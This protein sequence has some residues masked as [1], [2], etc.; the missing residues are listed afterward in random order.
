MRLSWL[1]LN[2]LPLLLLGAL[3]LNAALADS[4]NSAHPHSDTPQQAAA[5]PPPPAPAAATRA[6]AAVT[7]AAG[8]AASAAAEQLSQASPASASTQPQ[9]DA[10]R[11]EGG[12]QTSLLQQQQLQQLQ[13][14]NQQQQQQQQEQKGFSVVWLT[15]VH[16][17]HLYTAAAP[18]HSFCHDPRRAAAA[19]AAAAG[20][21]AA[22]SQWLP[23]TAAAALQ[24]EARQQQPVFVQ[25][26]RLAEV[27]PPSGGLRLLL[28]QRRS[29]ERGGGRKE[30]AADAHKPAAAPAAAA[31]GGRG[32]MHVAAHAGETDPLLG[33]AGCDSPPALIETALHFASSLAAASQRSEGGWQGPVLP[34]TA[35]V[36]LTGDYA[37]HFSEGQT[38]DRREALRLWTSAL[39][40]HFPQSCGEGGGE[41]EAEQEAAQPAQ[42]QQQ[43]QQGRGACRRMQLLMVVGNNDL[44]A[45]YLIPAARSEWAH[46]L[47]SLWRGALPSAAETKEA[48][49]LYYS[50]ELERHP[51]VS[52]LCLNTVLYSVAARTR[53]VAAGFSLESLSQEEEADPAGQFA[54]LR[55][56]LQQART[57]KKQVIIAGHIPPGFDSHL[58]SGFSEEDLWLPRYTEKYR[59]LITEFADSVTAQLFGHLHFG[60]VRAVT[61]EAR[62]GEEREGEAGFPTALLG[63][64]ALSPIH[65]NN[66]AM[67]A[68][69]FQQQQ[70]S[71][72][73]AAAAD[74]GDSSSSKTTLADYLQYSL[75]LY[76]FVG[77]AG[78]GGV[79]PH[80]SFEYSL[81]ATFA[82]FMHAE[83]KAPRCIDGSL[84]IRMGEALRVY[85][86]AYAL[87]EWH[88]AAGGLRASSRVRSCEVLAITKEEHK[89]CLRGGEL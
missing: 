78:T 3:L 9:S 7:A 43:Q 24:Q 16:L 21:A 73:V 81:H 22:G 47:F 12:K 56:Q 32:H 20:A 71:A 74:G 58:V 17:D 77:A 48:S 5:P 4:S 19:G 30:A 33:R 59:A 1:C 75:P 49:G 85:P 23:G 62:S 54:W 72:A 11:D 87:Y 61:A 67:A 63:A 86:L 18:V 66:P 44:A 10:F 83:K 89:E 53:L 26:R 25:A 64:P 14:Q 50:T 39:L 13:Q 31:A 60:R 69:V 80:F 42:Q 41:G 52:V 88:A 6:A 65:G 45:D 34:P 37:A 82:P 35:A 46:F 28:Q 55:K 57:A 38:A 40:R 27:P 79:R 84:A 2:P 29:M 51:A 15:D 76:G 68:L 8:A 36:L 70:Q